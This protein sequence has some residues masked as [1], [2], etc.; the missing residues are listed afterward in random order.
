MSE[1]ASAEPAITGVHEPRS[2][3]RTPKLAIGDH[4]CTLK[5]D[6]ASNLSGTTSEEHRH[7]HPPV[8]YGM[9]LMGA[10]CWRERVTLV[11]SGGRDGSRGVARRLA[12]DAH[13]VAGPLSPLRPRTARCRGCEVA[14]AC[15]VGGG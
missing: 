3:G 9:R 2:L 8:S 15:S 12:E 7:H 10:A 6:R 1:S 4:L 13:D 14:S 11:D 5:V